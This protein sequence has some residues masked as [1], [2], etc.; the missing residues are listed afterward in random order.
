MNC[1]VLV[2]QNQNLDFLCSLKLALF[3][4]H[5]VANPEGRF[6]RDG[7]HVALCLLLRVVPFNI[8]S[9]MSFSHFDKLK[10]HLKKVI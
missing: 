5:L 1:F 2:L 9:K 6:S 7:A 10:C 4:D 3:L 8:D